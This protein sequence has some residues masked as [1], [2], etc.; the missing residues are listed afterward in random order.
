V[1][2]EE[3]GLQVQQD[4]AYGWTQTT[5]RASTADAYGGV[6]REL[7]PYITR[8]RPPVASPKDSRRQGDAI[9][10]LACPCGHR[11]VRAGGSRFVP[12]ATICTGCLSE[13]T[14]LSP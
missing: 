3:L 7:D 13:L 10:T 4:S 2:A 8:I 14:R 1:V 5:L 6:L 9:G 12:D 11:L